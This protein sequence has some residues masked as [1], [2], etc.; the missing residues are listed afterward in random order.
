MR[1]AGQRLRRTLASFQRWRPSL[2][3]GSLATIVRV[4]VRSSAH[5]ASAVDDQLVED[6]V[7]RC[8]A[9]LK[10]FSGSNRLWP[11][12]QQG[13]FSAWGSFDSTWFRVDDKLAAHSAD[14]GRRWAAVRIACWCSFLAPSPFRSSS[15]L[16]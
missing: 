3:L 10:P 13:F 14:G 12:S 2:L 7:K 16:F 5:C 4:L 15:V 9:L 8:L 6:V 1:E 11:P